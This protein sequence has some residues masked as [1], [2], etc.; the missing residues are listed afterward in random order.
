[1]NRRTS[2][3]KPKSA[4]GARAGKQTDDKVA[5]T[6]GAEAEDTEPSEGSEQEE[7]A[8]E[9]QEEEEE[10]EEEDAADEDRSDADVLIALGEL[11]A[12]AA[13]AYRI[14]AASVEDPT[15]RSK[16]EEF[17]EDHVRHVETINGLLSDRE[18]QRSPSTSTKVV[19]P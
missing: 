9:E 11:D 4:G 14:V 16:L 1:M 2:R 12:E 18:V 8:E 19:R 7:G 3:A 10:E 13:L 17:A 6:N 5:G 15:I